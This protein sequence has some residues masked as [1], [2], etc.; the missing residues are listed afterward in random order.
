MRF[1]KKYTNSEKE[2]N[3]KE[4]SDE[5]YAICELLQAIVDKLELLRHD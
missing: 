1:E 5:A 4:I 2:E 3:K